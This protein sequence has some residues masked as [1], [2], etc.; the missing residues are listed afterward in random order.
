M[1]KEEIERARIRRRIRDLDIEKKRW[2]SEEPM[3]AG[4]A[5]V[6]TKMA[7]ELIRDERMRLVEQLTT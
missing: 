3:E 5:D 2:I 7:L 4:M 1:A 6:E